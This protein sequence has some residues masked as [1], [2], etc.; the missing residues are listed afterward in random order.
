MNRYDS[1]HEESSPRQV[2]SG[3]LTESLRNVKDFLDFESFDTEYIPQAE[4]LSLI[5][6][7]IFILPAAALVQIGGNKLTAET[8]K[9]VYAMLTHDDIITVMDNFE[10]AKYKIR[11]KKTYLRT[12]LYNEVF[13]RNSR[14][15]NGIRTDIPEYSPTRKEQIDERQRRC[16]GNGN[17]YSG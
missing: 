16:A 15:I 14:V 1:F 2:P 3:S 7:E 9:S 6:A 12:A 10:E 17:I 4:E 8:V 11:F 5:I 13:E